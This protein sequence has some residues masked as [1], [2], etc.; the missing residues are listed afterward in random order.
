MTCVSGSGAVLPLRANDFENDHFKVE[1][2][3]GVAIFPL[4]FEISLAVG[5]VYSAVS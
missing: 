5:G 1:K 2:L 3:H 4:S